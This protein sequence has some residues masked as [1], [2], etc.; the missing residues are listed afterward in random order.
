[1]RR[2]AGYGY[3]AIVSARNSQSDKTSKATEW[4]VYRL[5]GA[6]AVFLG[7]IRAPNRETALA[8][9]YDEF[10]VAPALR[11]RIIVQRRSDHT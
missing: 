6:K 3:Y 1:M 7:S 4:L 10:D 11:R 9:A 2:V 8:L 5:G